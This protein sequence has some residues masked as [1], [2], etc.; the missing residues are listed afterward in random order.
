MENRLNDLSGSQWL[1][2]T[3]TIY[4]TNF[5]PD[6]SHRLRKSHGAMKPPELMAEIVSFFS[7]TGEMILD[8]FAGVGGTILGAELA[9]R[10]AIGIEINPLW[11]DTYY[12]AREIF[13]G[14]AHQETVPAPGRT[15]TGMILG[16]CFEVMKG[17]PDESMA[18]IITD[19]PYGC[20]HGAKGFKGE[21]NFSMNSP[22]PRDIGNSL[23]Y[24]EYL[25][26]IKIFGMEAFR[27]LKPGRYLI[28]LIG[29]RF[30]RGEFVPL[31]TL[32]AQKLQEAGF[33]WKGIR[34]WWNKATQRPLKPYAVKTCF[35]PN[36]THQNIIILRKEKVDA[37]V[38]KPEFDK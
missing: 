38:V 3:N 25:A 9:G 35:I 13:T 26:K 32:V 7:K 30:H 10:S 2:W 36:I 31:G 17:M 34:I 27:I 5:P 20:H 29:D 1:Y 4:E 37:E 19:P 22:D 23:N 21:T 16:D 12:Q 8:P 18:A 33:K 15:E 28:V 24:Q 6:R 14:M 11:V